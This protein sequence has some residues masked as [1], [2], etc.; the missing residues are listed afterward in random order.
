MSNN[1]TKN[2]KGIKRRKYSYRRKNKN[3]TI[4]KVMR[5]CS[6]Q[7]GGAPAPLGM[8]EVPQSHGGSS[9]TATTNATNVQL[10]KSLSSLQMVAGNKPPVIDNHRVHN[11]FSS[12]TTTGGD[13]MS[14]GSYKSRHRRLRY[15]KSIG[16]KSRSRRFRKTKRH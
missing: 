2:T 1:K 7:N 16:R 10:A 14:G 11:S 6:W 12:S 5:G 8:I 9:S 4:R 3:G 13:K 15:K